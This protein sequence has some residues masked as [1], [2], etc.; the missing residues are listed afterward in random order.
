MKCSITLCF[1]FYTL[2]H[3]FILPLYSS[4]FLSIFNLISNTIFEAQGLIWPL[5][6]IYDVTFVKVKERKNSLGLKILLKLHHRY[7]R[8]FSVRLSSCIFCMLC[9]WNNIKIRNSK[10]LLKDFSAILT[11]QKISLIRCISHKDKLIWKCIYLPES[12]FNCKLCII[13]RPKSLLELCC[14]VHEFPMPM[15]L[16]FY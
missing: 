6:K 5:L 4:S 13:F 12:C 1:F 15:S 2:F 9:K 7:F 10:P 8:G 3:V 14:F 16:L 11:N